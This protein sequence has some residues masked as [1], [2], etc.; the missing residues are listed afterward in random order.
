ADD[1]YISNGL[2]EELLNALGRVKGIRVP[3]RT[4]VF[5]F[6]N[7]EADIRSI[8]ERLNVDHA[9]EGSVR[10]SGNQVRIRAT[11]SD[12]RTGDQLWSETYQQ[13]ME[14][15][16][17]LQESI[18]NTIV[19]HLSERFLLQLRPAV[20]RPDAQAYNLY[21]RGRFFANKR[22]AAALT[23]AREH[24]QEALRIDASYARSW[25]G[26]AES[27]ALLGNYGVVPP[28]EAY[29]AAREAALKALQLDPNLAEAHTTL[30]LLYKDY[31]WD[32]DASK[33]H[34]EK[35]VQLDPNNATARHQYAVEYL[36]T[37]GHHAE[38]IREA[39][40]AAALDPL[41]VVVSA[42]LGRVY[43]SARQPEK[44][45]VQLKK[46]L[47]LEP[48]FFMAHLYMGIAYLMENENGL[49]LERFRDAQ[50]YSG[51][52][53]GPNPNSV[54]YTAVALSTAGRTKEAR[55]TLQQLHQLG[56]RRYVAPYWFGLVNGKL[57]EWD[58]AFSWM[59]S[60]LV[61]RNLHLLYL[62][63]SPL[64]NTF[65][66]DPRTAAIL[67]KMGLTIDS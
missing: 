11:L 60:A 26:L 39:E 32:W 15:L 58:E 50:V 1:Q 4:S 29:P 45:I 31:F 13:K 57:G 62:K 59:D 55:E 33:E 21:L 54:A 34:F 67:A 35:A 28:S 46:T 16:F 52:S 48:T 20:S 7:S 63:D 66:D 6:Q 22:N 41:S 12:T 25:A 38:A 44:A 19:E 23:Q 51:D 64:T 10:R 61:D 27:L 18:A 8:G 40:I 43:Y 24:F 17:V 2:T 14:D 9:L 36:S 49:A 42:D 5:A 37:M 3:S 65:R 53:L 30:A 47:E 56:T